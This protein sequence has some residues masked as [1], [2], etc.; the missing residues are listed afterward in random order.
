M[1]VLLSVL[2]CCQLVFGATKIRYDFSHN[3][4]TQV[5]DLTGSLNHGEKPAI[6]S[7]TAV[8]TPYG[9]YLDGTT[10]KLPVNTY[11]AT[12]TDMNFDNDIA[13]SLFVRYLPGAT[14]TFPRELITFKNAGG[15]PRL[16]LRQQ[17]ATETAAPTFELSVDFGSGVTT[18]TTGPYALSKWYF[19]VITLHGHSVTN[20]SDLDMCVN[21]GSTLTV[22]NTHD[23]TMDFTD[24][25]LNGSNTKAIY[26]AYRFDDVDTNCLGFSS[27]FDTG[28]SYVLYEGGGVPCNTD[29]YTYDASCVDCTALC[30][31]YGCVKLSIS[32]CYNTSC[33]P[34][35][36]N[37]ANCLFCYTNS[38]KKTSGANSCSCMTG[39]TQTDTNPL[40]CTSPCSTV[41]V[42]YAANNCPSCYANSYNDAVGLTCTCNA[43]YFNSSPSSVVCT[44]KD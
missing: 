41:A 12:S 37:T 21:G 39:Y 29:S 40:V 14:G 11:R 34:G 22:H 2:L 16:Q 31:V 27:E 5:D 19:F 36:V 13:M 35:T 23:S 43:G 7:T 33:P 42:V 24:N 44:G 1:V 20:D 38:E 4:N 15:V 25:Y 3:Y 10:V 9:L 28:G 6:G 18:I 30:G 26:Y 32:L 8:N 17:S